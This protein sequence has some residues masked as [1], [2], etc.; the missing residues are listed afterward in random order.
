M[1][2]LGGAASP[3]SE[4]SADAPPPFVRPA[5]GGATAPTSLSASNP[6]PHPHPHLAPTSL[7]ASNRGF[8]SSELRGYGSKMGGVAQSGLMHQPLACDQVAGLD[9]PPYGHAPPHAVL[10]GVDD[11]DCAPASPSPASVIGASLLS[12]LDKNP[13]PPPNPNPNPNPKP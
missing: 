4:P 5:L 6:H 10:A 11:D 12:F 8:P 9:A 7:S 1:N 2:R 13:N 3:S